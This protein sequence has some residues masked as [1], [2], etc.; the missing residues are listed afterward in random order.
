MSRRVVTMR[1]D[2]HYKVRAARVLVNGRVA[3]VRRTKKGL[4]VKVDLRGRKEGVYTV[5]TAVVTKT[6]KLRLKTRK[7]ATCTASVKKRS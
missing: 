2:R 6:G 4:I 5:R 7:F 1:L 3:K